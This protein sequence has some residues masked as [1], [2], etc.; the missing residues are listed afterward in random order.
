MMTAITIILSL[1]SLQF[2][3]ATALAPRP[4][5]DLERVQLL[6][7]N[8]PLPPS[9]YL[10]PAK[11]AYLQ[12]ALT[13]PQRTDLTALSQS[14]AVYRRITPEA[15]KRWT[16]IVGQAAKSGTPLDLEAVVPWVL[17]EAYLAAGRKPEAPAAKAGHLT[18]AKRAL[19]RT[20]KDGRTQTGSGDTSGSTDDE[21]ELANVDLQ[22]AAQHQQGLARVMSA[23]S[24]QLRDSAVAVIQNKGG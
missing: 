8:A 18:D 1:A 16:Q 11:E 21:A 19:R 22:Q 24:K 9:A 14:I 3:A 23:I 20:L 17:R 12:K 5:P 13:E 7:Q 6:Q 4:L 15:A 2:G 10:A